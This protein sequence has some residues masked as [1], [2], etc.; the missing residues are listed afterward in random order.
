MKSLGIAFYLAHAGFPI[1]ADE[2]TFSVKDGLFTSIN[3]PD[4]IQLGYSHFYAEVRRVRQAA[5]LVAEGG[6]VMVIFD[7]LFKGTNVKDAY[8]GTLCVTEALSAYRQSF[9]VISTHIIEVAE[10]LMERA[11]IL[12]KYM[13][14]IMNKEKPSYTFKLAKGVTSDRQ[15]MTIIRN[16]GILDLL[17]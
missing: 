3:V 12:F 10:P 5:E 16:E 14:T 15:G 1:P 11:N 9:F 13:P 6:Q 8:E 7:E 17:S 2:M 4:N